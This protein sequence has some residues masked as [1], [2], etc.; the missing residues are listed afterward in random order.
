MDRSRRLAG[1]K[2]DVSQI[3]AKAGVR[4]G[5][6]FHFVFFLNSPGGPQT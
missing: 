3:R 6:S 2:M 5:T 1:W 4:I